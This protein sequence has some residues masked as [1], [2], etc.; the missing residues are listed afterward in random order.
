MICLLFNSIKYYSTN[1]KFS[2]YTIGKSECPTYIVVYCMT[3]F[4][5]MV[6]HFSFFAN[7]MIAHIDAAV[8]G[9]LL[10]LSTVVLL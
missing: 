3:D 2:F 6:L 10:S 4:T 5:C 1:I 7:S 8:Y 9:V